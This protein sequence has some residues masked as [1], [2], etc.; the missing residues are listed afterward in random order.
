MSAK[1]AARL[2]MQL[3]HVVSERDES[4]KESVFLVR[5]DRPR[6]SVWT[7]NRDFW[8]SVSLLDGVPRGSYAS[9][10][11]ADKGTV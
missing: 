6:V 11:E 2:A 5:K 10:T 3:H 8:I 4:I 9:T 1:Q 7:A